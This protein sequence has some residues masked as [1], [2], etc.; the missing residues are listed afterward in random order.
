MEIILKSNI[1]QVLQVLS[2]RKES[3][4]QRK[5]KHSRNQRSYKMARA[6]QTLLIFSPRYEK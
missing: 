4:S 3:N 1:Y 5:H 2:A 6:D